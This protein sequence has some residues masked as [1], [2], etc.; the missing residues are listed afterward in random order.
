MSSGA[1]VPTHRIAEKDE[2]KDTTS[3]S[4][5]PTKRK[6]GVPMSPITV[7]GDEPP[8]KPCIVVHSID[9]S[10]MLLPGAKV[11][12]MGEYLS[13]ESSDPNDGYRWKKGKCPVTEEALVAA[14][15]DE[16]PRCAEEYVFT[17]VH[18]V[19]SGKEVPP[20]SPVTVEGVVFTDQDGD[21]EPPTGVLRFVPSGDTRWEHPRLENGNIVV[22]GG[23]DT[24]EGGEPSETCAVFAPSL[25]ET[26]LHAFVPVGCIAALRAQICN[27]TSKK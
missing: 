18:T 19:L 5:E 25:L 17:A 21:G 26:F 2:K 15:L 11:A 16:Y 12:P 20:M 9:G 7:Q 10:G 4:A 8:K 23:V 22:F 13:V 3:T 14:I 24:V 1:P 27:V 6:L